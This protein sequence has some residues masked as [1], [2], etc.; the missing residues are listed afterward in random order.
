MGPENCRGYK[1]DEF[2]AMNIANGCTRRSRSQCTNLFAGKLK[3]KEQSLYQL[4]VMTRE[5]RELT[6]T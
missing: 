5:G 3:D 2:L 1:R 6:L 4:E